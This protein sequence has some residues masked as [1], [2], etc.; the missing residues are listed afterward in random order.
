MMTEKEEIT[1]FIHPNKKYHFLT[2]NTHEP[3]W[4]QV[5]DSVYPW[6]AATWTWRSPLST[7]QEMRP[8]LPCSES[9]TS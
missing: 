3:D 8:A 4:I 1:L 9:S 5:S 7:S 2:L 6:L